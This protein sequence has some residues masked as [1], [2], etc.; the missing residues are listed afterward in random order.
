MH[1]AK[2]KKREKRKR[3]KEAHIIHDTGPADKIVW[4]ESDEEGG[5][6]KDRQRE[7]GKK[8]RGRRGGREQRSLKRRPVLFIIH[9][10]LS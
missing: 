8:G 7:R 9:M 4:T 3:K 10:S 2:E 1:K 5:Q 6:D